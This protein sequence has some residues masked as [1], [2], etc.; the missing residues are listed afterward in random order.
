MKKKKKEIW[1]VFILKKKLFE[2]EWFII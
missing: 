1:I 2:N